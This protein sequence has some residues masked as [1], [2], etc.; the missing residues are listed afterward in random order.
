VARFRPLVLVLYPAQPPPLVLVLVLAGCLPRY[1]LRLLVL[2]LCC[3][4]LLLVLVL[5]LRWCCC[6]WC[7]LP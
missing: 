7:F 2:R 3:F 6:A 4:P 5:V 1:R